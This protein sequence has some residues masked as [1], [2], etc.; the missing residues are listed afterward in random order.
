MGRRINNKLKFLS[1]ELCREMGIP[2]TLAAP[3]VLTVFDQ[4]RTASSLPLDGDLV[5]TD[6][7][8]QLNGTHQFSLEDY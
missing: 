3:I 4:V 5:P 7:S 2:V 1:E 6:V 8:V